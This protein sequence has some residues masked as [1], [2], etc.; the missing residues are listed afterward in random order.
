MPAGIAARAS[1]C[2][3]PRGARPNWRPAPAL[4]LLPPRRFAA[5]RARRAPCTTQAVFDGGDFCH[6]HP[7]RS[8][9]VKLECGADE[10][11]WG[12]SEPST[13]SYSVH[14]SSP[15]ACKA[16]KLAELNASLQ[17]LLAEEAALQ[18]EIDAEEA[19]RAGEL[20]ALRARLAGEGG[21]GHDEL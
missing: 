19:A 12:A 2:L 21:G 3:R 9:R 13:C 5:P 6:Q 20:A 8:L 16:E 17:G 10:R 14:A 1:L 7:A 15:A 4:P 18:A 11:A